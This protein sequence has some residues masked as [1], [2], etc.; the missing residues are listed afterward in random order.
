[1]RRGEEEDTSLAREEDFFRGL[2]IRKG[3]AEREDED[4]D[5]ILEGR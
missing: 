1:L 3:G 2:E 5:E 4:R